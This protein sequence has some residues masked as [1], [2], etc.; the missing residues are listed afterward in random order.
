MK[1][2]AGGGQTA[3]LLFPGT[4]G[5]VTQMA[6]KLLYSLVE[7]M[8]APV[9]VDVGAGVGTFTAIAAFVPGMTVH[10]FEPNPDIAAVLRANVV[11]N[12]LGDRVSVYECALSNNSCPGFLQCPKKWGLATLAEGA[13]PDGITYPVRVDTLDAVLPDERIDLLKLDVEGAEKFVLLGGVMTIHRHRP[14]ILAETQNKRTRMFGYDAVDITKLLQ[15]WGYVAQSVTNR[16]TL[17]QHESTYID[18]D[19]EEVRECLRFTRL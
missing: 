7:Q 9:L 12:G 5:A 4:I 13:F 3:T 1:I 11:R 18:I 10:A 15:F 8:D 17:Y 16:D 6:I 2:T 19:L 14:I